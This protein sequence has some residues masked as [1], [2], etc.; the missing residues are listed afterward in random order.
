MYNHSNLQRSQDGKRDEMERIC[1][2][3]YNSKA[4]DI[5]VPRNEIRIPPCNLCRKCVSSSVQIE[6]LNLFHSVCIIDA[7]DNYAYLTRIQPIHTIFFL[8]H[9]IN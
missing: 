1:I 3:P 8:F 4:L 7:I 9:N 6:S 2:L 5:E